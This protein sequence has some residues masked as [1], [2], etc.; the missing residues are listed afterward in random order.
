MVTKKQIAFKYNMIIVILL[1]I[2]LI[3]G[4]FV[5]YYFVQSNRS[6]QDINILRNQIVRPAGDQNVNDDPQLTEKNNA[7]KLESYQKLYQQNHDLVGWIY[8]EGTSVDFPV[9]QTKTVKDYY[10]YKNFN[11]E[12]SVSGLPYV[13]EECDV[14]QPTDN[15]IIHGHHRSDGTMFAPLLK[16]KDYD[17]YQQHKFIEFDTIKECHKYQIM[18]VFSVKVNTSNDE[19]AYYNF[20][21][22]ADSI[23]FDNYVS[24]CMKYAL[25]DTGINAN[26]GD[27][28]LTISTC[29]FTISDGRFVVV[30]KRID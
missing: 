17:F 26:Y 15:V 3:S 2:F 5:T 9:M 28:L 25:Y 1:I 20:I 29:D 18:A 22:A 19:F 7:E 4:S 16:Y 13:Q 10:L 27:K 24:Q 21:D 30:A 8:I 23:D 14:F 12:Y 11:E 6:K